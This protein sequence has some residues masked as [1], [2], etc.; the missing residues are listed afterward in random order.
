MGN[1]A[2]TPIWDMTS[3]RGVIE[4]DYVIKSNFFQLRLLTKIKPNLPQAELEK[5]IYAFVTSHLDYFNSLYVG[6][7]QNSAVRL[8]TN[9]K[10]REHIKP[11]LWNL[12]WL[13]VL[14]QIQFNMVLIVF[15]CLYSMG[16]VYL[17][18]LLQL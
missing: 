13:L 5:A 12:H 17:R 11:V 7:D 16:P 10:K 18:E 14:Y 4:Y 8:L 2:L 15:K 1:L 9:T 3:S 6:L